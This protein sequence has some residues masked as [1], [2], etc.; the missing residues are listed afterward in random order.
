MTFNPDGKTLLCGLQ[1]CLKV[2]SYA[3]LVKSDNGI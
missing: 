1:E 2:G 3:Y